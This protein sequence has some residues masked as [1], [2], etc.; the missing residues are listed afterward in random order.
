MQQLNFINNFEN[1]NN[2]FQGKYFK[3]LIPTQYLLSLE[4]IRIAKITRGLFLYVSMA[5]ST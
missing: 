5:I 3:N 1:F 2:K 4:P